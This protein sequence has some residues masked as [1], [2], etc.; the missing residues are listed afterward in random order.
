M[1]YKTYTGN[2]GVRE[3]PDELLWVGLIVARYIRPSQITL[4]GTATLLPA[5]PLSKRR[6][7]NI[8]NNSNDIIYIGDSTVTTA[9]GFPLYPHAAMDISIE[10]SV[11]IYGVSGGTSSDIRILEGG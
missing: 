10:D 3:Q 2:E 6:T 4:T 9:N 8:F 1:S 11:N 5:V 7:L